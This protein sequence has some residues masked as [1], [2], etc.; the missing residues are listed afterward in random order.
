MDLREVYLMVTD[1]HYYTL[2]DLRFN[3]NYGFLFSK[4]QFN[5]FVQLKDELVDNGK[6]YINKLNLKTFNSKH[7]F[8]VKG[9]YWLDLLESYYSTAVEDFKQNDS[10]LIIRNLNDIISSRV[11]S[12]I[13]GT[14]SIENIPTTRKRISE[15]YRKAKL[16][17][18]N[19]II[20][21]NMLDAMQYII[22]DKPP[23]TKENLRKLYD[24]LSH[25]CLADEDKLPQGSYYRN[26]A[27]SIDGFEGA[28]A[29]KIDELMDSLFEFANNPD[30]IKQHEDALPHICHYYILYVHPYFDY[31]GRTARMVSFWIS[32]I[33]NVTIAPYFISEAI[34]ENKFEYYKAIRN[35]RIMNNDLTYFLGYIMESSIK[36]SLLYKNLEEIKK[37]FIGRGDFLT[38]TELMYIK[39]ILIHNADG[40]F[41]YK[42][43]LEYIGGKMTKQGAL[44]LLDRLVEYGILTKS[45]NKKKENIYK[46]EQSLIVYQY[47]KKD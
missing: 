46:L 37:K 6:E 27:V 36:F 40:Y 29:D 41:N 8:Y 44:K 21:K 7:C 38:A 43:F 14:L 19:D 35:S 31:N 3:K 4:E 42:M 45:Q 18:K 33:N 28:D 25:D 23:F 15:I 17:D 10:F 26:D 16:E 32:Y 1:H 20:I 47:S 22:V 34:N 24:I 30:N 11:F 9:F 2:E 13:E 39:K 12:E 5:E